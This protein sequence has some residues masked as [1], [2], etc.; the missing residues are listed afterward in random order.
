MIEWDA[1]E[2]FDQTLIT[3]V[4]GKVRHRRLW[5]LPGQRHAGPGARVQA[6]V[7]DGD[8]DTDHGHWKVGIDGTGVF[9]DDGVSGVLI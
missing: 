5:V 4:G 7:T 1:D 2:D 9:N 3:G 8:G 6:Q